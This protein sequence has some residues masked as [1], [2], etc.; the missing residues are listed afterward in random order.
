MGV[1]DCAYACGVPFRILFLGVFALFQSEISKKE[2]A[3]ADRHGYHKRNR[4][5]ALLGANAGIE[6]VRTV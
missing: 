6:V 3:Y 4:R 2:I 5:K 1:Y